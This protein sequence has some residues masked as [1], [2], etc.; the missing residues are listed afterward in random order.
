MGPS[1]VVPG[2]EQ[3]G[4]RPRLKVA[5]TGSGGLIGG[6]L[7]AVLS[8]GGHEVV[9]MVRDRRRADAGAGVFWDPT[10]GVVDTEG[11]R[12]CDALVH[13]AGEPIGALR[14]TVEK[15][16]SIRE[17]RV[18][19]TGLIAR[20]IA[21][22]PDGPSTLVMASAVGTSTSRL[23]AMMP[24]NADMASASRAPM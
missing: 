9:R 17:S 8:A 1:D 5:I 14:W 15:K 22:L 6:R 10:A 18:Q 19:G 7:C 24:P 23:R 3:P 20:S 2:E 21:S 4:A 13:L 16:R 11:L 12:G